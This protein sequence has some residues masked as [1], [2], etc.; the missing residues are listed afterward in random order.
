[1]SA[2]RKGTTASRI[3]EDLA[4][5]LFT[6][7][8]SVLLRLG[9]DAPHAE[10][11][12]REAF[13]LAAAESARQL[14][15]HATQS[16]V[17][18]IAGISRLDVRN[19]LSVHLTKG[20]RNAHS[21]PTRIQHLLQGWRTDPRF[22]DSRGRP[23]PL[24]LKGASSDFGLLVRKYGRDVTA[25]TL[26]E[27]LIRLRLARKVKGKIYLDSVRDDLSV[28]STGALNDLK[29]LTTRLSDFNWLDG[30]RT[31]STAQIAIPMSDRKAA[32][33]VRRIALER[34]ETVLGSIGALSVET[35]TNNGRAQTKNRV[36]VTA[37]IAADLEEPGHG[38]A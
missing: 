18:S 3:D 32:H 35:A 15:R 21:R 4:V 6:R 27:Q 33:L 23:K 14:G 19:I 20:D 8:A 29:F 7:I 5:R 28:Q 31:F 2:N 10:R 13:V 36:L 22:L 12:V 17:A 9:I 30:R 38:E 24:D 26:L 25:R 16:R 11:I 34:I 37:S 1:V